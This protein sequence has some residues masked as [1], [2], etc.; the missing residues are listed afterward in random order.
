MIK[1]TIPYNIHNF[2]TK[3]GDFFTILRKYAI[4]FSQLC[5]KH[6]LSFSQF[7]R[8]RTLH[9]SGEK[10]MFSN[11]ISEI[12]EVNVLKFIVVHFCLDLY[13]VFSNNLWCDK[14]KVAAITK[15]SKIFQLLLQNH[16]NNWKL[17]MQ[18]CS[19]LDCLPL[20]WIHQKTWPPG[21]VITF[22][23]CSLQSIVS[24]CIVLN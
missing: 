11:N 6:S 7:C 20:I 18:K 2:K 4:L 16:H 5:E 17:F 13:Q 12:T 22:S 10:S 19:S 1:F 15:I 14:N 23:Y 9:N 3:R 21:T 24:I 8:Y